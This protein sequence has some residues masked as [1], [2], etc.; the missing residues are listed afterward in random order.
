MPYFDHEMAESVGGADGGG[1]KKNLKVRTMPGGSI[2]GKEN[3]TQDGSKETM[4]KYK[5][6][7]SNRKLLFMRSLLRAQVCND[8]LILYGKGLEKWPY[9]EY[10]L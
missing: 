5:Q 10:L 9:L 7:L 3:F 6:K 4:A 8:I 2:S 1:N